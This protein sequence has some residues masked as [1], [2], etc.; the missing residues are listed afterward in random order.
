MDSVASCLSSN[1][2]EALDK[3]IILQ[4]ARI[5]QRR[6]KKFEQGPQP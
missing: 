2:Q 6:T 3:S 5:H 1:I 4:D